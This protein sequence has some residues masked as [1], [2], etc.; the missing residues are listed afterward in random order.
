MSNWEC[1]GCGHQYCPDKGEPGAG[2]APNTPFED[3]PKRYRCPRCGAKRDEFEAVESELEPDEEGLEHVEDLDED[4][5]ADPFDALYRQDGG[6]EDDEEYADDPGLD[7]LEDED[8]ETADDLDAFDQEESPDELDK[9]PFT[10]TLSDEEEDSEEDF[11]AD[12]EALLEQDDPE[13]DAAELADFEDFDAD[14]DE[15]PESLEREEEELEGSELDAEAAD[16]EAEGLKDID[17]DEDP[18]EE[19]ALDQSELEADEDAS[20]PCYRCGDCGWLYRP[21]LGLPSA[22]VDPG[23][24]FEH[25]LDDFGCP[26]CGAPHEHFFLESNVLEDQ[27]GRPTGRSQAEVV[28]EIAGIEGVPPGTSKDGNAISELPIEGEDK[29]GLVAEEVLLPAPGSGIAG[30]TLQALQFRAR[31]LPTPG[32][33]AS[34]L[35]LL[36]AHTRRPLQLPLPVLVQPQGLLELTATTPLEHI[37]QAPA[38]AIPTALDFERLMAR[39]DVKKV[40]PMLTEMKRPGTLATALQLC[41]TLCRGPVGVGVAQSVLDPELEAVTTYRVD[42]LVLDGQSPFQRVPS[43]PGR[44]QPIF[45]GWLRPHYAR[46]FLDERSIGDIQ[47]L[48]SFARSA[49]DATVLSEAADVARLIALGAHAVVIS[50]ESALAADLKALQHKLEDF[51]RLTGVA[52]IHALTREDLQT[53]SELLARIIALK[54]HE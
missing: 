13:L 40:L 2:I 28:L 46:L 21:E 39:A 50:K 9:D 29:S 45:P 52:H 31:P 43:R 47:L 51:C 38:V 33:G 12:A 35:T 1:Q 53:T 30:L 14:L 18:E 36:G 17:Y 37:E 26:T 23:T 22:G 49:A 6:A 34:L 7:E 3:L 42:F 19:D 32:Q 10:D 41:R 4:L 27:P 24:L 15:D 48:V 8:P 16:L 20:D 54:P 25:L 5:D 11:D 44:P